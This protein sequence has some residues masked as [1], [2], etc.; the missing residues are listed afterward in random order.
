MKKCIEFNPNNAFIKNS[1]LSDKKYQFLAHYDDFTGERYLHNHKFGY[2]DLSE[3]LDK[4]IVYNNTRRVSIDE[5]GN[6]NISTGMPSKKL[7]WEGFELVVCNDD[8]IVRFDEWIYVNPS[9]GVCVDV[10]G[11]ILIFDKEEVINDEH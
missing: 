9:V 2:G 6:Y 7:S 11:D 1:K 4:V 8:D 5:E 3:M 10:N